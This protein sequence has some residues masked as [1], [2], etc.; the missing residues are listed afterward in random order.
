MALVLTNGDS[1]GDLSDNYAE[2]ANSAIEDENLGQCYWSTP[3]FNETTQK[4][5]VP[6]VLGYDVQGNA[7][8]EG[9]LTDIPTTEKVNPTKVFWWIVSKIKPI[10]CPTCM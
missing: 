2:F 6:N 8:N 3:I 1:N 4:W 5:D 7:F 9:T 10:L